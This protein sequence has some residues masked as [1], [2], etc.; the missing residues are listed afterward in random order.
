MRYIK[1]EIIYGSNND[2]LFSDNGNGMTTCEVLLGV[3]R[4]YEPMP[5]LNQMLNI[6]QLR[7]FNQVLDTLEGSPDDNWYMIEDAHAD[8]ITR[9]LEWTIPLM[10]APIRRQ[11]DVIT[12]IITN[13]PHSRD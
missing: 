2:P 8:V 4:A 5:Q 3:L 1:S 12:N 11:C 6:Q 10:G 7:I 13:A 9:I